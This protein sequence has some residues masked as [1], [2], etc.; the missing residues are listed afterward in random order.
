LDE[1]SFLVDEK[2]INA[3]ADNHET[4]GEE[5]RRGTPAAT[6]NH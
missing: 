5:A 1:E 2:T 4:V 6:A 3:V